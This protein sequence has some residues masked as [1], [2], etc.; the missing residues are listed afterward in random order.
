MACASQ[1]PGT[2]GRVRRA[3]KQPRAHQLIH[4]RP[5]RLYLN[6]SSNAFL[7]SVGPFEW[8][9]RSTVMRASKKVHSL[10]ASL[11]EI[12]S[13][14][15]WAHSKRLLVSNQVHW[16]HA[17]RSAPHRGHRVST[18]V[19]ASSKWPHRA[20]R[21]TSR[22]PGMFTLRGSRAPGARA[23]RLAHLSALLLALRLALPLIVLVAALSILAVSHRD[24][25]LIYPTVCGLS[26]VLT[27]RPGGVLF[28]P[29]LPTDCYSRKPFPVR[30]ARSRCRQGSECWARPKSVT[31]RVPRRHR[32]G[33]VRA[34]ELHLQ[35]L[36]GLP[37]FSVIR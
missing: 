5:T 2:S 24:A 29:C 27:N 9:S 21:I 32:L 22:K 15:G 3:G 6:R 28:S 37:D 19:G 33:R 10:R 30:S 18:P 16:A 12:R 17:W 25:F 36:N 7:V 23:P 35:P 1:G 34:A 20:Q 8:V 14:T 11:G 13:A 4:T 26:T 31:V